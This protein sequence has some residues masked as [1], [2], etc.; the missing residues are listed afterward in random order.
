M[1]TPSPQVNQAKL[2]VG[3]DC[4]S[5]I[6]E[7]AAA[8]LFQAGFQFA[9][10]Y[11]PLWDSSGAGECSTPE[12]I[13]AGESSR[14]KSYAISER[15]NFNFKDRAAITHGRVVSAAPIV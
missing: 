2:G 1:T 3:F 8:E 12:G 5:K 6:G 7:D 13:G 9:C 10:R 4:D 14:A 11:V 15:S